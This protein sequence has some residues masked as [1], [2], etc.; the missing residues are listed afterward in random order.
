MNARTGDDRGGTDRESGGG[1]VPEEID[2]SAP[3]VGGDTTRL[4]KEMFGI[5]QIKP[6]TY[7][8]KS[9]GRPVLAQDVVWKENDSPYCPYC[10][11]QLAEPD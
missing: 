9:C 3:A 2:V 4:Y 5:P 1:P 11:S 6:R 10:E 8:C 7:P